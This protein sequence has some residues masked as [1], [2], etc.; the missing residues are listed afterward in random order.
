MNALTSALARWAIA[1]AVASC[2]GARRGGPQCVSRAEL[3]CLTPV[4]CAVDRALGCEVC[5][6]SDVPYTPVGAPGSPIR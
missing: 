6:C 1:A 3:H 4:E 5:R 2:G